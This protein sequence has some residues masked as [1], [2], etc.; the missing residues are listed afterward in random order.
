MKSVI[1]VSELTLREQA[2]RQ[3]LFADAV[4]SLNSRP[5]THVSDEPEELTSPSPNELLIRTP[6]V[7]Q[8]THG[9]PGDFSDGKKSMT[10]VAY[11]L[12]FFD[13]FWQ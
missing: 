1:I 8:K 2:T 4:Y 13:Q 3:T 5:L 11:I 9:A 6:G 10:S 7:T 12:T